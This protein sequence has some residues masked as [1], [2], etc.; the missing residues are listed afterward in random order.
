MKKRLPKSL[1]KHIRKEKARIRQQVFGFKKQK[2]LIDSLYRSFYNKKTV[3]KNN[4]N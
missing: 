3:K 1:R 4:K 2:E